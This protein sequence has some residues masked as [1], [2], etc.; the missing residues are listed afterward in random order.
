MS[1]EST[2]ADLVTAANNLTNSVNGKMT[3]IDAKVAAA[4]SS[5]P[6]EIAKQM[7][8]AMYVDGNN[9][10]D[11]NSGS[12]WATAKKTL[13]AACAAVPS[14]G[15]AV[16][17][18]KPG[19]V[20]SINKD[21]AAFNKVLYIYP[22]SY[23]YS[24]RS[25]YT[26]VRSEPGVDNDGGLAGSGF[27][28][29]MKGMVYLIGLKLTTAKFTAAHAGK[30][31]SVYRSALFKSNTSFGTVFMQHCAVD[32]WN[33]CMAYQHTSGS[34]GKIDLY[35]RNVQ[36][37]K[38]DISALPV[39]TGYQYMMGNYGNAPIPF[40]MYGIEM[41]RVGFPTWASAISGDLTNAT[42][43]LKD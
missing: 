15:Y 18:L 29:G 36:L 4:V 3:A 1:L 6:T 9:G 41:S 27:L 43:N 32:V 34:V 10:S 12:G 13:E 17:V 33:A 19:P 2:I 23:T 35:M 30:S 24:D 11:A 14:G 26:E 16:I 8:F 7:Y 21:I 25:T 42:T 31:H 38:M 20:Y 39:N 5:V 28:L 37:N 40:T 22:E